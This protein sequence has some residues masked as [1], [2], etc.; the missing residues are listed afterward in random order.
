[1]CS[2]DA[3]SGALGSHPHELRSAT[4]PHQWRHHPSLYSRRTHALLVTGD[5]LRIIRRR[6]DDPGHFVGKPSLA[7]PVR[8]AA[9]QGVGRWS[10]CVPPGFVDYVVGGCKAADGA[11][12]P[13]LE[14]GDAGGLF[15]HLWERAHKGGAK[16]HLTKGAGASG[17]RGWRMS[18]SARKRARRAAG[19][20]NRQRAS[21]A[22][23]GGSGVGV[24][25]W[26]QAG[27]RA[28]AA[29]GG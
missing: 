19:E 22:S 26:K 27:A 12:R 14:A 28:N 29:S 15:R 7:D 24:W 5:P 1:M 17:A 11:R 4:Q 6:V 2:W 3:A 16:M 9:L 18:E 10:S 13:R 25:R 8:V 23:G 21:T 20:R